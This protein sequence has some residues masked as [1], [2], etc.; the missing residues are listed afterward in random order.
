M[1]SRTPEVISAH[2]A[3]TVR[4]FRLRAGLGDHAYRELRQDGFPIVKI[5]R[6]I[7]VRGVDW[8]EWLGKIQREANR[9]PLPDISFDDV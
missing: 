9:D 8:L 3:Y 2:E 6:K 4:E 7:Y 1:P 5:G